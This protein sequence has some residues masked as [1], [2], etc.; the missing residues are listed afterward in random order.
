[1]SCTTN[2]TKARVNAGGFYIVKDA[3]NKLKSRTVTNILGSSPIVLSGK[4]NGLDI[5]AQGYCN[6]RDLYSVNGGKFNSPLPLKLDDVLEYEVVNK[7]N[8]R[9]LK[10]KRKGKTIVI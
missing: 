4:V 8:I 2:I 6:C 1:M 5:R 3:F 7:G 9:L 10:I